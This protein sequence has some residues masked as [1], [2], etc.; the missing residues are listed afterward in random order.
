MS[1]QK[2]QEVLLITTNAWAQE[3]LKLELLF[4]SYE[5]FKLID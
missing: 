3:L 1:T 2:Y 4:E 5:D